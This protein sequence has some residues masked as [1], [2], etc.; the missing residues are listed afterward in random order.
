MVLLGFLEQEQELLWHHSYI[1]AAELFLSLDG[2]LGSRSSTSRV[3]TIG[4][5]LE[6]EVRI[7]PALIFCL[8]VWKVFTDS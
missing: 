6:E 4:V 3:T 7:L 5:D 1:T 8:T 2:M